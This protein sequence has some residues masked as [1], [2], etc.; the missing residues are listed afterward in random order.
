MILYLL[1][2]S[3]AEKL[4]HVCDWPQCGQGFATSGILLQHRLTH[5]G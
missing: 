3:H 2:G 1:S 5:K 4:P